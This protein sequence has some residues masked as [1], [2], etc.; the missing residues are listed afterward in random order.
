[1]LR[2][3]S[4]AAGSGRGCE[5]L[6]LLQVRYKNGQRVTDAATMQAAVQ[7]A[8]A[9]RMQFEARLSKV[10]TDHAGSNMWAVQRWPDTCK[11]NPHIKPCRPV[12]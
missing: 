2:V 5:T 1:M 7:A 4:L 8:G 11:Q 3:L 9:A 6:A 10:Q 12:I